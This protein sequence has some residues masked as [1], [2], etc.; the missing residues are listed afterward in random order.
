M[1][2]L[3]LLEQQLMHRTRPGALEKSYIVKISDKQLR[4]K[5]LYVFSCHM[6]QGTCTK[7]Y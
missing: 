4:K 2:A 5:K 3:K 7:T 1:S 6:V